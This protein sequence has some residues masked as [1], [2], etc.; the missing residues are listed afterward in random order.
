MKLFWFAF[1]LAICNLCKAKPAPEESKLSFRKPKQYRRTIHV[2]TARNKQDE[3]SSPDGKLKFCPN[4]DKGVFDAELFNLEIVDKMPCKL[5]YNDIELESKSTEYICKWT[6]LKLTPGHWYHFK[7][8]ITTSGGDVKR[9]SNSWDAVEPA[10]E[11]DKFGIT[12]SSKETSLE[13]N[14]DPSK[15][16][17]FWDAL[18][19]DSGLL[20]VTL[21]EG[22]KRVTKTVSKAATK[23]E[24]PMVAFTGLVSHKCYTVEVYTTMDSIASYNRT[25]FDVR[26]EGK[27]PANGAGFTLSVD[28]IKSST[29][30]VS[31][32][33]SKL[34]A[35]CKVIITIEDESREMDDLPQYQ[36]MENQ[37]SITVM[38]LKPMHKYLIVGAS[39]CGAATSSSLTSNELC[40]ITSAGT[41]EISFETFPDTKKL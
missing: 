20:V 4:Y 9:V 35:S 6:G 28:E 37:T 18:I 7:S 36:Y 22:E 10:F 39:R 29:A 11:V 17:H 14:L 2:E 3:D 13:V 30:K 5:V 15:M 38:D 1:L 23:L 24:S 12:V 27:R 21:I 40:E 26:T 33:S 41:T 19:G 16:A 25:W 34:E 31:I 32:K 8:W